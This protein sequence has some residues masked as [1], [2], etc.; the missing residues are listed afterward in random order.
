MPLLQSGNGGLAGPGIFAPRHM[1]PLKLPN[2]VQRYIA[3]SHVAIEAEPLLRPI[4]EVSRRIRPH[5]RDG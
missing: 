5:L 4:A 3:A 2:S 1:R